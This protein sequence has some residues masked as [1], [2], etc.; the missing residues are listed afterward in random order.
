MRDSENSCFDSVD[1]PDADDG[2]GVK[3]YTLRLRENGLKERKA[4]ASWAAL[5]NV[6]DEGR[7]QVLYD[8]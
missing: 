5:I 2:F 4:M 7:M 3:K 6:C 1:A 8:L